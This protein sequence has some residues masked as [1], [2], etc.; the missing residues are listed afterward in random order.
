MKKRMPH[1]GLEWGVVTP[2]DRSVVSCKGPRE[3]PGQNAS[4]KP[5][6]ESLR[7]WSKEQGREQERGGVLG[8]ID[9]QITEGLSAP[10]DA[11]EGFRMRQVQ[12][13]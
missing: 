9:L 6:E 1:L 11:R 3:H 2:P 10:Q 7:T 4:L 13:H 8:R 5:S 12:A